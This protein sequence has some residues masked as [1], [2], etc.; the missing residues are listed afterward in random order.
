MKPA[1]ELRAAEIAGALQPEPWPLLPAR[2]GRRD[3][4]D[5][6]PLTWPVPVQPGLQGTDGPDE[7]QVD[8]VLPGDQPLVPCGGG[9]YRCQGS[10]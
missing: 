8:P 4:Q 3:G 1:K 5:D 6:Q 2:S 7:D 9:V 10:P